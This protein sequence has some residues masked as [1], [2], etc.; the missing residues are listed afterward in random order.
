M[1]DSQSGGFV[2]CRAPVVIVATGGAGQ[3]YQIT[4]NP[5]VA[6]GDGVAAAYR[7]G[8]ELTDMEFVQ[9]HPTV[10]AMPNAPHF[11]ISEAVRGGG[12]AAQKRTMASASCPDTTRWRSWPREMWSPGQ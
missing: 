8:A 1:L 7:A 5:A 3:L 11:L 4:T 12:G 2:V 6:T 10:L 9:F